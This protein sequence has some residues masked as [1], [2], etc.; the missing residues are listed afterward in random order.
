MLEEKIREV[1]SELAELEAELANPELIKDQK[2]YADFS[3]R[4]K[5]LT[6]ITSCHS[7]YEAVQG[8][9]AAAQDLLNSAS[10]KTEQGQEAALLEAEIQSLEEK[11]EN[12]AAELADL[13][14]PKDP[15][16]D[17][18]VIMEI[19]GAEGGEE[20]NIFAKDLY[21]MYQSYAAG[22]GWQ[23]EMMSVQDS[24]MGGYTNVIAMVRGEN[25]WRCLKYEGGPHRVQRVP[26]TESQGRIHT[27]SATVLVMPEADEIEVDIKD[28]DLEVDVYRSSGPGGQ[29]VN[30]TDS[31]VR[32]THKPTG[33]TVSMQDEKSQLQN[34]NKAMQV[35]R[36]RIYEQEKA[37]QEEERSAER[38]GQIKGGGRAEKIRTYNFKD[39]RVTDHRIG[40]TLHKLDK[41]LEGGMDEIVDELIRYDTAGDTGGESGASQKE[42]AEKE[43]RAERA[44]GMERAQGAKKGQKP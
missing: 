18:D 21:K 29:S 19:R 38:K 12:L 16:D 3:R 37:R 13:V 30:T 6:R 11:S 42:R 32:V 7:D 44:E 26:D 24:P 40:L 33:I 23:M 8:D 4:H 5:K 20:A 35:L 15:D 17:K 25:V 10:G 27:S 28:A 9:L 36:A 39:N 1:L 22:M 2:K 43:E 41:V 14:F 34:R 31:A